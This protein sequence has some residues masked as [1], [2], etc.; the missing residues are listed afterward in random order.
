MKSFS[1]TIKILAISLVL[2]ISIRIIQ[3][4]FNYYQ[5]ERLAKET[6]DLAALP[7]QTGAIRTAFENMQSALSRSLNIQSCISIS[8]SGK[9]YAPNCINETKSY[10]TVYCKVIGNS[11]VLA[12]VSFESEDFFN[13]KF[14]VILFFITAIIAILYLLI[15]S[16]TA[17]VLFQISEQIKNLLGLETF[18]KKNEKILTKT[19]Q[20]IFN[21]L[22]VNENLSQFNLNIRKQLSD[23]EHR[24]SE[25]TL[26]KIQLTETKNIQDQYIEKV[27]QIRHDIRSPLSSI[28]AAY[29]VLD[30]NDKAAQS[31]ASAIRRIQILIDDLNQVD[32]KTTESKLVIAEVTLEETSFMLI[33]KFKQTKNAVLKYSYNPN[34]LTPIHV[35]EN[36]FRSAIE[37]LLEN[38]LDALGQNGHV[39]LKITEVNGKCQITVTDDG[40]GVS[41]EVLKNLFSKGAT[42]GKA[43]GIGLGLYHAKNTIESFG[44]N[45]TC[46][47]LEKGTSFQIIIPI[48]QTGV[49]FSSLPETKKIKIIDDDTTV[50]NILSQTGYTIVDYAPTFEA[51]QKLLANFNP[52][53]DTCLVDNRLDNN[54]LGTELIAGQLHRNNIYLCTNE[55]DDLDL[56]KQARA[57]CVKIIPKPLIFFR[58]IVGGD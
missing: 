9:S 46:V 48:I 58:G 31:I 20:F 21:K 30:K 2:S 24:L 7:L 19:I 56:I 54:K 17:S 18:H 22:G 15:Q 26:Q 8:D 40:C 41:P 44:G 11:E 34:S 53:Q 13:K 14:F 4:S 37:N 49:V 6:C 38:S 50:S 23:Y 33:S 39:E 35:R 42:S 27:K 52:S 51:G 43:N 16:F 3:I 1:F 45:I 28:Q 36:D 47:P 10:Q 12:T 5:Q 32:K 29:D 55:Y 25:N 57:I